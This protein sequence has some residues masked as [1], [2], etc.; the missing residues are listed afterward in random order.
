MNA[1]AIDLADGQLI[2]PFGGCQDLEDRLLRQVSPQA[3]PEDPLRMLRG[4][5]LAARFGLVIESSTRQAMLTHAQSIVSIA[6]ERIAEELGKLFQAP[7][8]ASGFVLMQITGLLAHLMPELDA[9]AAIGKPFTRTMQRLDVVQQSPEVRHRG[10][11]DL[12]LA[13]LLQDSG[14]PDADA[15]TAART[16]RE[17]LESLRMTVIGA[18]LN[19]I[20]SLIRESRLE[21][22]A[23]ASDAALRHFAHRVS[24]AT[25]EMVFDLR[26]SDRLPYAPDHNAAEWL[27]LQE[28]LQR[29]IDNGAPLTV[30][31]LALDGHDLQRLGIP[32]GPKMGKLLA[33]LLDQVLDDPSRNTPNHLIEL[34]QRETASRA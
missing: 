20:E 34:V 2:D 8:P 4:V 26:L 3:F 1:L 19:L 31:D 22:G 5:Q 28:R 21:M 6:P 29:E 15:P 17:R 12:L 11:L 16:A 24:P 10:D 14:Y 7:S 27:G 23:L 9:L 33:Y 30:Q 32:P 18:Q 25:A 13:A